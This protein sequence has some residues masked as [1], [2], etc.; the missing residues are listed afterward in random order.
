MALLTAIQFPETAS[1]VTWGGVTD[2]F[3]TYVERKDLR[4]MMKRVIGGS[5]KKGAKPL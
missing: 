4:R 3:L 2:M 1:V 5:P